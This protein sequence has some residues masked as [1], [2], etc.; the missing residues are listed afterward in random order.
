VKNALAASW[1]D[2][3]LWLFFGILWLAPVIL[4]AARNLLIGWSKNSY[5]CLIA[6]SEGDNSFISAP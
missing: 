6:F 5:N 4:V 3:I 1:C 2:V